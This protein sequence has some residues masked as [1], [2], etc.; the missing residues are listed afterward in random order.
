MEKKIGLKNVHNTL[1]LLNNCETSLCNQKIVHNCYA[2][3][4]ARHV[5]G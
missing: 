1:Y 4:E 2:Y 5:E 3:E